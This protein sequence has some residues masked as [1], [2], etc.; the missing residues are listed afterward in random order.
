MTKHMPFIL[1]LLLVSAACTPT[2]DLPGYVLTEKAALSEDQNSNWQLMVGSWYGN[3]PV[4]SGGFREHIVT[5]RTDGTYL[6]R[7]RH[8][9]ENGVELM[10]TEVGQWGIVGPIY[11]SIFRGWLEGTEL[12]ASDPS[13]P[14][15]YDAYEVI[16]LS[17]DKF[18]YRSF[19][20]GTLF[21]VS[22]VPANFDFP[23]V[24]M[25]RLQGN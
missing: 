6:I 25:P 13:D 23:E 4:R 11:F 15:N 7:A 14:Y 2:S 22:K 16:Y 8:V 9:T 1:P 3:Q 19:S 10:Q 5:R 12:K 20:S 21:E 24:D 17:H 18:R